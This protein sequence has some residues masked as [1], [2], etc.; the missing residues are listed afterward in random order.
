LLA[1]AAGLGAGVLV[2]PGVSA[3][4]YT[5]N[6]KLNLALVGCGGRGGNLLDSFLR[7]GENVVALCDANQQRAASARSAT[8]TSGAA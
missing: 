2:L 4:A 7:I 8:L 6:E 5:A 1:G 3:R